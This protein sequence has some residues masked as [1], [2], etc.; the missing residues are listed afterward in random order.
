MNPATTAVKIAEMVLKAQDRE[1]EDVLKAQDKFTKSYDKGRKAL[2]KSHDEGRTELIESGKDSRRLASAQL[3]NV[4]ARST[5]MHGDL[6]ELETEDVSEV[7]A[8]DLPVPEFA[9]VNHEARE[10]LSDGEV[11][12]DDDNNNN[13]TRHIGSVIRFINSD[14][15]PGTPLKFPLTNDYRVYFFNHDEDIVLSTFGSKLCQRAFEDFVP[16]IKRVTGLGQI[17]DQL[18]GAVTNRALFRDL[19]TIAN[20]RS[21]VQHAK[22]SCKLKRRNEYYRI[23]TGVL[24]F[25]CPN[26]S[27]VHKNDGANKVRREK[28]VIITRLKREKDDLDRA[29]EDLRCQLGMGPRGDPRDAE[30]RRR[31][32]PD[33]DSSDDGEFYH[34]PAKRSC[35]YI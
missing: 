24:R 22:W 14:W 23:M 15:T 19:R 11:E 30:T 35:H 17:H 21:G 20:G 26:W 7:I 6:A 28:D 13:D 4:V 34:R 27:L 31:P 9:V 10:E 3:E 2:T 29:N 16:R 5:E 8:D 25:L 32:R 1:R 12:E 18:G 33:D